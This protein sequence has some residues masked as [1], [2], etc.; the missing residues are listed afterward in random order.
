MSAKIALITGTYPPEKC[1]VGDYSNQ[2]MKSSL[3]TEWKLFYYTDWSAK[4][5][6]NKLK[7]ISKSGQDII[8][9]QYPSIGYGY[10]IVPHLLCLYFSL[11]SR[12]KISVTLHEY[13]R[14]GKKSRFATNLFLFFADKIVFTN[15]FERSAAGKKFSFVKKKSSVIKI[16]SNIKANS[17]L[18]KT[19]DR[20][21]EVGYFGLLTPLKGLEE[22]IEV[23]DQLKVSNPNCR[24]YIMG[25]TVPEFESFSI[26]IIEKAKQIGIAL[27]LNESEEFVADTLSNTKICYLPFPDGVSER[28]GSFL[29]AVVNN[30]LILT[31]KGKFTTESHKKICFFTTK[32]EAKDDITN[33]LSKK[34]DFYDEYQDRMKKFMRDE[35]PHS[36]DDVAERYNRL[37]QDQGPL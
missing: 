9:I 33:L 27:F 26:K 34:F 5:L 32:T 24:I 21:L 37:F 29:A 11:F 19:K 14:L 12:K 1:G 18:P 30:C 17:N 4:T 20:V 25:Q 3:S 7:D 8:N 31:N 15:E 13:T 10:S 36:W 23:A 6:I 22:F 35:L 16:F 2:L 28:R